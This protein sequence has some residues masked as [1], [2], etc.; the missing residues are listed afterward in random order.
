MKGRVAV[1]RWLRFG[2]V[3]LFSGAAGSLGAPAGPADALKETL[4]RSET[5]V[6][7]LRYL[8]DE[9]GGRVTGSFGC[10]RSVDWAMEKFRGAG[11]GTVR[12]EE[13]EIPGVWD[14]IAA[15]AEV[16][17]PERFPVRV[18][19]MA[20]SRAT[21]PGGVTAPVVDI[22]SGF[23][24]DF[25]RAGEKARGAILLLHSEIL[26]SLERLFA[27]YLRLPEIVRR[28]EAGGAAAILEASTRPRGLLYRHVARFGRLAPL[29]IALAAR[30]AFL[31]LTRLLEAGR[32]V[33]VRLELDNRFG[34]N[35]TAWNV[36]ADIP[37]RERPE[38]V[39]LLGAHLDSWGMGTGALDN[40]CNVALVIDVARRLQAMEPKPRRTV[41]FALFTGEEQGLWG[42]R[43][44]V[45]AHRGEMDRHAA[46]VIVDLGS[47]RITGFSLGGRAELRPAVE[48]ILAP[49]SDW[50]VG[51][52]TEDAFVGTDNFDF[53]LEGVPNLV[54]NQEAEPYLP[55]YHAESDTF[56]KVDLDALRRNAAVVAV[57]V[58]GLADRPERIGPRQ[59]RARVA[60]LLAATGVDRQ[61]RTFEIWEEWE[62]RERGRKD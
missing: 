24:E 38:E 37:G 49:V 22:G 15:R 33:R 43:G 59:D 52:H 35:N 42:S 25:R 19:A 31:R 20:F 53:L 44:Y 16:L 21:P 58:R 40:G 57:L 12:R 60:E 10:E 23:E 3:L 9:I 55:D 8:C 46:A 56:D 41:R 51:G 47:G 7:D 29:P 30:E 18:A 13:F 36:I 1:S 50:S 61:M 34:L 17:E 27:E 5:I 2:A 39:V 11:I 48:E 45:R 54:A 14:E 26:D 62:K 6:E 28:A 4:L 32:E